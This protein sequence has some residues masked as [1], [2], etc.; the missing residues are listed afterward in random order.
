MCSSDLFAHGLPVVCMN[1][2]GPGVMVD[3][4]C[5]RVVRTRGRSRDAVV[6]GLAHALTE[7]ADDPAARTRLASGALKRA[8]QSDWRAIVNRVYS[9]IE[10]G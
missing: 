1:L 6:N 9:E 10:N 3:E 8:R 5:G 4:T 7:L 2:G